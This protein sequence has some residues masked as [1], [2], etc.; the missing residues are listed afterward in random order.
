MPDVCNGERVDMFIVIASNE[1]EELST[2]RDLATEILSSD[3]REN[4]DLGSIVPCIYLLQYEALLEK[5][6]RNNN[7]L[8][9]CQNK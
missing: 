4:I 2:V 1:E 3:Y 5:G 9:L 7:S 6:G 8:T